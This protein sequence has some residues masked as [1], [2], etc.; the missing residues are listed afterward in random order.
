MSL[1]RIRPATGTVYGWQT[2]VVTVTQQSLAERFE[3]ERPR[4]LGIAYRLT[5]SMADAEDAVQE[6]LLAAAPQGP[7]QGGPGNPRGGV[8][9]VA[10]RRRARYD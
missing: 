1:S 2:E 8:V 6:A 7:E 5:G 3:T 9:T 4:L 10:G